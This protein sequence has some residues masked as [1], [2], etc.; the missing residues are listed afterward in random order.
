MTSFVS[1]TPRPADC[2]RSVAFGFVLI[3]LSAV[4]AAAQIAISANDGDV[5]LVNGVNTPR[6][7]PLPDTVTILNTA[8]NPPRVLGEVR[9]PNSVLGPPHNVAI[10]PDGTIALVASSTRID[11]ENPRSTIPDNRVTVIDLKA[12][13]PV[14]LNTLPAGRSASGV[15]INRAGSLALVANRGE[16]TISVFIING[17]IVSPAGK[18]DLGA[19]DSQPAQVMFSADGQTA[20]VSRSAATDNK[21]SLLSVKLST[22]EYT[23][24][25][26]FTGLQPYGMDLTPLGDLAVI[27]NIGTGF[28]GGV[29]TVSLV[30][31]KV[32]PPRT[33]DQIAVGP[34]PEGLAI[35]PNGKYVAI[36][37]LNGTNVAPT[38][39]FFHDYALLKVLEIRNRKLV[40]IAE[41]KLGNWCQGVGW[42]PNSNSVMAQC[43]VEKEIELF[44]FD[45]KTLKRS[46][47]IKMNGGPA[48]LRTSP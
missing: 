1:L 44:T 32:D 3:A 42:T 45:G 10:S 19:P 26:I 5:E 39:P 7:S 12:T 4:S 23:K 24:R 37:I 48:G 9:A 16:G 31:L 2:F 30:D 40:P 36:T 15:A 13:P 43:M 41:A 25:D 35:S 20:F 6:S 27:A 11:P 14:V 21:V 47:E 46:G 22:V 8:V 34:I 33:I 18:V 38:S 28:T 29:D 17:K